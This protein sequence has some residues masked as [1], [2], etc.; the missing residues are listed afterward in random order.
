MATP[1]LP[2][3]PRPIAEIASYHAHIYYDVATTKALAEQ[4][5]VAQRAFHSAA[6]QLA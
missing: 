1:D 3:A 6:R 4:L 5:I 2:A